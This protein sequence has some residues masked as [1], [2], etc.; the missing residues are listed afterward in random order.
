MS[1][2]NLHV[3]FY[4]D[5]DFRIRVWVEGDLR[6]G[7][8]YRKEFSLEQNKPLPMEKLQEFFNDCSYEA[9]NAAP[10]P[11]N[12]K[13]GWSL[14]FN[15]LEDVRKAF[16]RP[17][18]LEKSADFVKNSRISSDEAF[19]KFANMSQG[20]LDLRTKEAK[21]MFEDVSFDG[22][23]AALKG[24]VFETLGTASMCWSETPTGVFDSTLATRIGEELWKEI[25]PYL[26][27]PVNLFVNKADIDS[28][29][30]AERQAAGRGSGKMTGSPYENQ[31]RDIPDF[32]KQPLKVKVVESTEPKPVDIRRTPFGR[33][34]HYSPDVNYNTD[35]SSRAFADGWNASAY[36]NGE[37]DFVDGWNPDLPDREP[38]H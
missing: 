32:M 3:Q 22:P 21:E 18:P 10:I 12:L 5:R 19:I 24:R 17:M 34:P 16:N 13:E 23:F 7:G 8:K 33:S 36:A 35:F 11:G 14:P 20:E 2:T 26:P 37:K 27:E 6:H 30:Q 1:N 9:R 29:K 15:N 28:I 38:M 4:L 31:D 25:L